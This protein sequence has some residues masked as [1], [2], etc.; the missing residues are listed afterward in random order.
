VTSPNAHSG[1][2]GLPWDPIHRVCLA[3]TGTAL[4]AV[5]PSTGATELIGT[6]EGQSNLSSLSFIP[7]CE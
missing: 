4:Y 2:A 5:A 7:E 1:A 3:S 6:I